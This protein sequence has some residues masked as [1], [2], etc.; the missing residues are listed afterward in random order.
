V[1]G[2]LVEAEY[3]QCGV[4]DMV[5]TRWRDRFRSEVGGW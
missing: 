1:Q 4:V 5:R 3:Y 2:I